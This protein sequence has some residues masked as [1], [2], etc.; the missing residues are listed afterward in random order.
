[1]PKHQFTFFLDRAEIQDKEVRFSQSETHHISVVLRIPRSEIIEVVDGRGWYYK[2]RLGDEIQGRRL[3]TIVDSYCH[4]PEPILPV[5][6]A[7]PCLK[8]D[9]WQ[10]ALET[11]CELGVNRIYLIDFQNA[12]VSW[13]TQ[14][15]EK[16]ERKAVEILKQCGGS[17]LTEIYGPYPLSE[18]ITKFSPEAIF[19]ADPEG[20]TL[21]TLP[22][23]C[24]LVIGP[25]AGLAQPER[26]LLF[27]IKVKR[28]S[29]GPRRL[30]S[31]I[32]AIVALAQAMALKT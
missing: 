31:E 12:V 6:I 10:L 7:L 30:R 15:K 27:Q 4:E 9:R 28:F 20:A 32:A 16:A 23:D 24:L 13:T 8:A 14:R 29:L 22:P 25:E 21:E 11:G 2:V 3:G 26:E 1:M 17:K 18:L 5:A 19:L